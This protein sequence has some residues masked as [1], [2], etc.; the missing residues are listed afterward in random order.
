MPA[1][2]VWVLHPAQAD[3]RS[4][5]PPRVMVTIVAQA[6]QRLQVRPPHVRSRV[7]PES[8]SRDTLTQ[9]H[10]AGPFRLRAA[11][12]WHSGALSIDIP[13]H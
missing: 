13:W 9:W 3:L 8:D 10:H 12:L 11:D 7:E 6:L 2:P 4:D 5:I 1:E